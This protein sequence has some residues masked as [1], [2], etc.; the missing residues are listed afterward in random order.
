MVVAA[1]RYLKDLTKQSDWELAF[2]RL[3]KSAFQVMCFAKYT[4]AFFT[5]ASSIS[6]RFTSLCKRL[7][8]ASSAVGCAR[9]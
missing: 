7:S 1:P 2:V 6:S 5:I 9:F 3:Y 4:A 8:S